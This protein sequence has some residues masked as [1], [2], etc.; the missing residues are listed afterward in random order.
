VPWPEKG[1]PYEWLKKSCWNMWLDWRCRKLKDFYCQVRDRITAARADLKLQLK[2]NV[3]LWTDFGKH[4]ADEQVEYLRE[5][6]IDPVLYHGTG[7][8]FA[9][10]FVYHDK[11]LYPDR[12]ISFDKVAIPINERRAMVDIVSY[13]E[14]PGV[15]PKISPHFVGW[16]ATVNLTPVDRHVLELATCELRTANVEQVEFMRWEKAIAQMEHLLRRYGAAFR[17]LPAVEPKEFKGQV[18]VLSG[19]AADET[20][21]IRWHADRLMVLNDHREPR[22]IRITIPQE[23]ETNGQLMELGWN[24]TLVKG[25]SQAKTVVEIDLRPYDLQVLATGKGDAQ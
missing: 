22:K 23:L 20:L 19:K 9:C 15:L 13:Y 12:S 7:I 11:Y 18:E 21:A 25:P 5:L 6:G 4:S 2:F 10:G 8:Q 1:T 14:L 3:G 16:L 17:A 24:R